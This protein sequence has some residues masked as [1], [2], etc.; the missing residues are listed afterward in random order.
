MNSP[1]Q[2]TT[3]TATSADVES[4]QNA[5]D[6]NPQDF[7]L[8]LLVAD[9]LEECGSPLADGYRA[10]GWLK[11]DSSFSGTRE[12]GKLCWLRLWAEDEVGD[13]EWRMEKSCDT[14]PEDWHKLADGWTHYPTRREAEDAAAIGFSRLPPDRQRELLEGRL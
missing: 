12:S 9:A 1:A 3:V 5:I 11:R 2:R 8:R 4:L 7:T 6:Q 10:L 13:S 14:L